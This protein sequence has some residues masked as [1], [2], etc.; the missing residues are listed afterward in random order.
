MNIVYNDKKKDL[1]LTQLHGLFVAVG[2]SDSAE[3]P[4]EMKAGFLQPW[5]SST[6]VVSAWDGDRLV[7]AVRVL[8]DTVFRSV[9]YDLL[10]APEYQGQG[11]GRELVNRCKSHYPG[12]EWLVRCDRRNIEFYE[13]LGFRSP[14]ESDVYLV[15]PCKFFDAQ[16]S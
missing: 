4:D 10:V 15:I 5:T 1:P 11:I 7:G 14:Q 12:S 16:V 2:W 8:S 6:L 13:K 9:I 3:L